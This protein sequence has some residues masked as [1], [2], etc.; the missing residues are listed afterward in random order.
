[1]NFGAEFIH[2]MHETPL[3]VCFG[4]CVLSLSPFVPVPEADQDEQ[5]SLDNQGPENSFSAQ[6][7]QINQSISAVSAATYCWDIAS[8]QITWNG[9]LEKVFGPIEKQAVENGRSYASLL[10]PDN[11]TSRFETVMRNTELDEGKGVPFSI[12]YSIK[13]LGRENDHSI[14]VEDIGRWYAGHD[15]RPSKVF[16]L[17]RQID[18]R[19]ERDQHLQ[20]M[21]NCDPLTGMMNRGRLTEA[22]G[23]TIESARAQDHLSAFLI[24]AI[25]NLEV[26][27]DAYG[28]DVADEVVT[29]IGKRLRQ[30]VRTGDVIGRYSGS[31]FG[32][33]LSQATQE[34][35]EVAAERFLSIARE[36]VI[37][38]ELGPVWASLS[39]GGLTVPYA[40]DDATT[41]MSH[42]EEALA[43]AKKLPTDGFVSFEP[44]K[45][46]ESERKLNSRCAVEIIHSL[47][48]SRFTLAYQP[49]FNVHT[50]EI[51]YY[52][53][54]LRMKCESGEIV[55]AGH[56][57][58]I[59]EKIGLVRLIDR[60]VVSNVLT[61]LRRYPTKRIALN[62]S[63]VTA[64]DP[65]WFEKLT[66]MFRENK[67]IT[68][69]L[70]IEITETVALENIDQTV[71]F[72]EKLHDLGCKV[73]IDD[74]GAGFTSFRNLKL[75]NVDKVKIDG[76]FCRDLSNNPENQYFVKT[77]IDLA[78]NFN[79]L[80]VAE[81][82]ENQ[83]DA[84][85]LT[86]WGVDYLQGRLHGMAQDCSEWGEPVND[87]DEICV[88]PSEILDTSI[89][90]DNEEANE[91]SA[92]SNN[93]LSPALPRDPSPVE[94]QA[95]ITQ[96]FGADTENAPSQANHQQPSQEQV[97][98]Q[99]STRDFPA[100][101]P[102]PEPELNDTT[103]RHDQKLLNTDIEAET[104]FNALNAEQN[105]QP[106]AALPEEMGIPFEIAPP[107]NSEPVS[108]IETIVNIEQADSFISTEPFPIP[109]V[110]P[111]ISSID[112]FIPQ[113]ISQSQQAAPVTDQEYQAHTDLAQ[114][115][116]I[117]TFE[118][119]SES[120]L[121]DE[122]SKLRQ[123]IEILGNKKKTS[124][125]Q[126]TL[127][128]PLAQKDSDL[129]GPL[130][131]NIAAN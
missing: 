88:V 27:N 81:W 44:S 105:A 96:T 5:G 51:E 9:D 110:K 12:E 111:E 19:H 2:P 69:R 118:I 74:F 72:I 66:D 122:L 34:E 47:K 20:F 112:A 107:A 78:K 11:F 97:H 115:E 75:L 55:P 15:G 71:G 86:S 100:F 104:Q 26:V 116:D 68:D 91:N 80:T 121:D 92:R 62:I 23:E 61:T 37:E 10:D 94:S 126:G 70:T 119:I 130:S 17:V 84:D 64:N 38:T 103:S 87:A 63:G 124:A 60:A 114:T 125:A 58:P 33:I 82:V 98:E 24:V 28:F 131:S 50:Q 123:A 76:S 77:L 18:D 65:R 14:W 53:A 1:M 46:V 128:A 31:K 42:A 3:F 52:E 101:T 57:V 45:D 129:I 93:L 54:L 79:L 108:N 85:L 95:L 43:E 83:Q 30:V 29:S 35:L 89:S 99:N 49:I 113:T 4:V 117:T 7:S 41:T 40:G 67:D 32:I 36:Q 90:L 56:L 73:A 21:G 6:F 8:D 102:Q 127:N 109:D 39:I 59:A 120:Q 16:G 22:L 13:P 106:F 48:D 25:A